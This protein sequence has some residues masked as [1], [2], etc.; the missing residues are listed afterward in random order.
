MSGEPNSDPEKINAFKKYD[1][2]KE[3]NVK[4]HYFVANPTEHKMFLLLETTT[5]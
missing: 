4:V 3:N 2:S 5:T 1:K